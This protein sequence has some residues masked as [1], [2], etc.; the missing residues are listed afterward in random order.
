MLSATLHAH[1]HR[2]LRVRRYVT[3]NLDNT[4]PLADIAMSVGLSVNQLER[5]FR[6]RWGESPRAL[7]RRLRL[8]RAARQL[9]S[10]RRGILQIALDARYESHEAFGRAFAKYFG[11]AP[12]VYRRAGTHS[13][14]PMDR[15]AYWHQALL[16]GLR[17][18]LEK[19][20]S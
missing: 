18:H 3:D 19:T 9:R 5:V 17:P 12:S 11:C 14:R 7:Q 4:L 2:A 6:R 20:A 8:E 15:E 13:A 16:V 1:E 10:T